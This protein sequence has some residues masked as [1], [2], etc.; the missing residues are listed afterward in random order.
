MGEST[1]PSFTF[2]V[3]GESG[4][5][6]ISAGEI[7]TLAISDIG[8]NVFTFESYPAEIKGGHCMYQVRAS[9][10]EVLSAGSRVDLLCAFNQEAIDK[11]LDALGPGGV[12]VYDPSQIKELPD[13]PEVTVYPIEFDTLV[14][15]KVGSP[16]SKNVFAVAITLALFDVP[17]DQIKKTV[18]KKFKG[19]NPKI[20]EKNDE[21]VD[22]AFEHVKTL[23]RSHE[24]SLVIVGENDERLL[25]DGNQAIAL[26]AM[27]A[28]CDFFGGYPITPASTIL[29]T[30]ASELPKLGGKV[31]QAED[32]IAAISM[33]VG[34]SYTG[35][36]SMT[37]TSGPGLSL[38]QEM[39]GHAS[40][41][42]LPIVVV[43]AMRGGP[44]TGLPTKA[45]QSDLNQMVYGCHGEA[46]R[47]VIAPS[48]VRDCF[49]Q[50]IWAFNLA[51]KYQVP[52]IIATDHALANRREN[53]PPLE[54]EDT[55]IIRRKLAEGPQEDY[56]RYK[57]TDDGVSPQAVPG[58]P[59]GMHVAEGLEHNE[60]GDP[61]YT[62]ENH[63]A[64]MDKRMGKIAD[65]WQYPRA[66]EHLGDED[67]DL[68]IV[69]W[70][71][72]K[73]PVK[74]ATMRMLEDGKKV[75]YV[76][77]KILNPLPKEGFLDLVDGAKE[78]LVVEM[79]YTGQL[80]G[81]LRKHH[82]RHYNRL[83][84]IMGTPITWLEIQEAAEAVLAGEDLERPE[85]REVEA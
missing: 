83:N 55:P 75:A 67:P 42:E 5:G 65:A 69:T 57:F 16:K 63:T 29:E 46:S 27:V 64:M 61:T 31:V 49:Y 72:S 77:P 78:V 14:K 41:L 32:E 51:E 18:R 9:T 59:G 13:K 62:G 79:N 68:L 19:K 36:K 35:A 82:T 2:R 50:T 73:G 43:D 37:A 70:G 21:A 45:E 52:V 15:E 53:L 12:L 25:I 20:L 38:M 10:D 17:A 7:A 39:F 80:E 58:T 60:K 24:G 47:I 22:A 48:G 81:L 85:E 30:L 8:F 6:V 66:V 23:E 76:C 11:H 3:A 40:T 74:E 54:L 28:G 44:S 1:I 84:K 4:E 26:G 56:K 34:A 33:I 71:S